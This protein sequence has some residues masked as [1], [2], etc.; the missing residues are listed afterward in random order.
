MHRHARRGTVLPLLAITLVALLGFVALSIDIGLMAMAR[1]QCQN[2]ADCA[3][4]TGARTLSG[5]QSANDN[6]A[7]CE[8]NARAAVSANN[9][10]GMAI[11]GSD[12][13]NVVVNI[14]AYAYDPTAGLFSIKLPKAASDPY[15]LVQ[16]NITVPTNADLLRPSVQRLVRTPRRRRPRPPTARGTFA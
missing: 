16:V 9:V 5:N 4:L 6:F 3:A 13:T 8:P 10:Q 7:N 2:A 12:T 1:T 11:N 14:G 15:D